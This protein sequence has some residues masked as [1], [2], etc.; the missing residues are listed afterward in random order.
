MISLNVVVFHVAGN[1]RIN[2]IVL[3]VLKKSGYDSGAS[4]SFLTLIISPNN[5]TKGCGFVITLD[6]LLAIPCLATVGILIPSLNA[7]PL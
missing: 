6:I 4:F 1:K 3:L 5:S 2:V 7:S